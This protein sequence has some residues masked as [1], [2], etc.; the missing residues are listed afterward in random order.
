L[1]AYLGD[2]LLPEM[3]LLANQEHGKPDHPCEQD[4]GD[5]LDGPLNWLAVLVVNRVRRAWR[6]R[7]VVIDLGQRLVHLAEPR[8]LQ[9]LVIA[10]TPKA[11]LTHF[12]ASTT[13]Q[14]VA[15]IHP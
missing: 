1:L 6:W 8:A 11:V 7:V 10:A 12:L 15:T 4:H 5:P 14:C 3:Q 13:V 2:S 9:P